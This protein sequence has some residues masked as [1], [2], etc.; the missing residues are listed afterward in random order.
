M[1]SGPAA[2]RALMVMYLIVLGAILF[3]VISAFSH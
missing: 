1:R 2:Q 3:G